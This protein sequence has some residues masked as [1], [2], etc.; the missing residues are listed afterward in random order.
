MMG[1]PKNR[2]GWLAAS[3]NAARKCQFLL[4]TRLPFSVPVLCMSLAAKMMHVISNVM[5]GVVLSEK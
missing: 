5:H 1:V 4:L 3:T 2:F